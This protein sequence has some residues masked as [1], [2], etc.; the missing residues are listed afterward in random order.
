MVERPEEKKNILKV[1]LSDDNYLAAARRKLSRERED[2]RAPVGAEGEKSERSQVSTR[3]SAGEVESLAREEFFE[4]FQQQMEEVKRSAEQVV[5]EQLEEQISKLNQRLC[6]ISEKLNSVQVEIKRSEV[7]RERLL[8]EERIK[9]LQTQLEVLGE[10][11]HEPL[12]EPQPSFG[13]EVVESS[14]S[15]QGF[16]EIDYAVLKAV[17]YGIVTVKDLSKSLQIR[18]LIIE[19]HV[20]KLIS[21]RYLR[22]FKYLILTEKGREA[23]VSYENNESEDVWRPIDEFILSVREE[24]EKRRVFAQQLVDRLL[25]LAVLILIVFIVYFGF[26]G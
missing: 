14:A 13:E 19:E 6:E 4:E 22:F 9:E 8:I 2:A 18:A 17:S 5:R 11:S 21:M 7:E 10:V 23:I 25:L 3:A 26:F 12:Q 15:K 1:L 24:S 20:D 16:N